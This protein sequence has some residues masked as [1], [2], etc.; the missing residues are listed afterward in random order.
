MKKCP[1][2]CF[3]I[4]SFKQFLGLIVFNN[5]ICIVFQTDKMHVFLMHKKTRY[6]IFN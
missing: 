1:L 6:V 4:I 2:L 3:F 5:V